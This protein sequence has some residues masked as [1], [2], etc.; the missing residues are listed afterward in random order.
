MLSGDKTVDDAFMMISDQRFQRFRGTEGASTSTTE[1]PSKVTDK[2]KNTISGLFG[3]N[4]R[5]EQ[6]AAKLKEMFPTLAVKIQEADWMDGSII[7]VDGQPF[8]VENKKE[9]NSLINKLNELIGN[10]QKVQQVGETTETT[11]QGKYDF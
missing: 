8:D 6:A 7:E 11:G 1:T 2:Q 9:M 4:A 3:K 5:E 10:I